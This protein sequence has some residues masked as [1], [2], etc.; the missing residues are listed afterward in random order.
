MMTEKQI[1][2]MKEKHRR[3][4]SKKLAEKLVDTV[5]EHQRSIRQ[6][7]ITT[8]AEERRFKMI[9]EVKNAVLKG[10]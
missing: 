3:L 9:E 5:M 7:E 4:Q 2:K 6:K 8:L 1:E 10:M